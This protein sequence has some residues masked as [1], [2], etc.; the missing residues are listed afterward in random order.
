[1]SLPS[2]ALFLDKDKNIIGEVFVNC[3]WWLNVASLVRCISRDVCKSDKYKLPNSHTIKIYSV[4]IPKELIED[5]SGIK[6]E[7]AETVIG[8][9]LKYSNQKL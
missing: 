2:T 4:T 1:M 6:F 8:S 7:D 9:Y 3:G 5:C